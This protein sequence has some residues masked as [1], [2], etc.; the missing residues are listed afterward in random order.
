MRDLVTSY[1]DVPCTD[2][3]GEFPTVCMDFDHLGDKEFNVG[4]LSK[5]SSISKLIAEIQK[6]E[7]VCSNCHRIRTNDRRL[8][9]VSLAEID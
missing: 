6:C 3:D 5:A 7:V 4:D 2:C 8:E 9:Q 1:K